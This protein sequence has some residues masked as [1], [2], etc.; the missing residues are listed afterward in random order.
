MTTQSQVR[1]ALLKVPNI[2]AFVRRHEALR[3]SERTIY[4]QR[5]DG[6]PDMRPFV[7]D[8]LAQALIE[9]GL[10]NVKKTKKATRPHQKRARPQ[11]GSVE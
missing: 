1:R 7:I 6:A 11:A 8:R 5:E 4:R 3:I 10:L 9:E 2:S